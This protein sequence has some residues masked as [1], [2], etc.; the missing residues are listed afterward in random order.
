M[1]YSL[2]DVG[3]DDA[4][5]LCALVLRRVHFVESFPSFDVL[6]AILIVVDEPSL[7]VHFVDNFEKSFLFLFLLLF[8]LLYLSSLLKERY[9]YR[10]SFCVF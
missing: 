8:L 2:P 9:F 6:F 7:E 10:V 1:D 3:F 4:R 5:E